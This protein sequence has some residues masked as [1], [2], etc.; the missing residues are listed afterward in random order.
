MPFAA[1]TEEVAKAWVSKLDPD[2]KYLL[3]ENHVEV[4]GQAHFARAAFEN[5]GKFR[6]LDDDRTGLRATLKGQF[7]LD[8]LASLK[9]RAQVA[10]VLSTWE[11]AESYQKAQD[12]A[13]A[14]DRVTELPRSLKPAEYLRLRRALVAMIGKT[15]DTM[16]PSHG[17]LG[18]KLKE[19]EEGELMV[20]L[21]EEVFSKEE[22]DRDVDAQPQLRRDGTIKVKR[23][24]RVVEGAPSN[25]EELRRRLRILGSLYSMV[26][27][28]QPNHVWF[29]DLGIETWNLH[30]DYVLGP[31]VLFLAAK[32]ECGREVKEPSWPLV[33]SYE[34]C[35]RKKAVELANEGRSLALALKSA[36]E[37]SD[38]EQE[39]FSIPMAIAP[40]RTGS[41]SSGFARPGGENRGT[42]EKEYEEWKDD[43]GKRGEDRGG[44]DKRAKRPRL[45]SELASNSQAPDGRKLCYGFNNPQEQCRGRC[46]KVHACQVCLAPHPYYLCPQ[47]REAKKKEEGNKAA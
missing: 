38:L 44:G 19:L 21:L 8:Q 9:D 32:D 15:E 20:E 30:A 22:A 27:V 6:L 2:L 29:K 18:Q 41:G 14:E 46:G 11:A 1:M 37:D 36:R 26:K 45:P 31:R 10:A 34:Y 12:G 13:A 25:T 43:K 39:H 35:I 40:P 5:V 28:R 47:F 24:A 3:D 42:K 7:G 17:M 16:L 33:L 23:G 4:L